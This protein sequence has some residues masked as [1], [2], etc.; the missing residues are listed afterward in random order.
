MFWGI[1]G[2]SFFLIKKINILHKKHF[3]FL[4]INYK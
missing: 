2:I 3:I 1:L 4:I